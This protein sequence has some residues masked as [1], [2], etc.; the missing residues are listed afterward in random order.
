MVQNTH[1]LQG[2]EPFYK[3]YLVAA[4]LAC[5]EKGFTLLH[6]NSTHSR[7]RNLQ[8]LKENYATQPQSH[9]KYINCVLHFA[10][11]VELTCYSIRLST[12]CKSESA[13]L[14]TIPDVVKGL[15]LVDH[16]AA[17][18]TFVAVEKVLHDAAFAN[19]QGDKHNYF[20]S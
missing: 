7:S 15:R 13:D 2:R 18:G 12:F 16:D 10:A 5:K 1:I 20:R 17:R 14:L 6:V 11:F 9:C 8:M 4:D 19:C 3:Q